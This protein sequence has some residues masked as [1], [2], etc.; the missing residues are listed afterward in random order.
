MRQSPF[1]ATYLALAI[2]IAASSQT[3]PIPYLVDS[4]G[5][6]IGYFLGKNSVVLKRPYSTAT[7]EVRVYATGFTPSDGNSDI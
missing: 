7:I 3:A 1:I 2:T 6:T 4:G 5:K